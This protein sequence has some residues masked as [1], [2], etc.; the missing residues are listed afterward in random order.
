MEYRNKPTNDIT[1]DKISTNFN[2]SDKNIL[3]LNG[4]T[5]GAKKLIKTKVE[6]N[7]SFPENIIQKALMAAKTERNAIKIVALQLRLANDFLF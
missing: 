1:K 5:N 7:K 4:T 3:A 2:G 6:Y